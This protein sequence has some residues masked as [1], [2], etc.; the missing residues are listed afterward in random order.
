MAPAGSGP[1][2]FVGD[3]VCGALS[4]PHT[5]NP[6]VNTPVIGSVPVAGL[7]KS[8][9]FRL[10]CACDGHVAFA[11][12][13]LPEGI[14]IANAALN[15]STTAA[16][17]SLYQPEQ[18]I[19]CSGISEPGSPLVLPSSSSRALA[20]GDSIYLIARQLE[21]GLTTDFT[22]FWRCSFFISFG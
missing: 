11:L 13:Y 6:T 20:N 16:A 8:R 15:F 4:V 22:L 12:I 2:R 7:R 5:N 9:G 21:P 10:E 17:T 1:S 19:L 3:S 18:Y 14:A